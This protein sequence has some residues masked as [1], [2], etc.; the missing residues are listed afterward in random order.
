[1]SIS[2][3]FFDASA[4]DGNGEPF[5]MALAW[6]GPQASHGS[7]DLTI[8][9]GDSQVPGAAGCRPPGGRQPVS[10]AF[11]LGT[12]VQNLGNG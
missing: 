6:L 3:L 5:T 4:D 12:C 7:D 9:S 8:L 10:A 1:M 11:F 2:C